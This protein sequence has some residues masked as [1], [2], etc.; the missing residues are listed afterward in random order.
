MESDLIIY[1]KHLR[2][3]KNIILGSPLRMRSYKLQLN[4]VGSDY[5]NL[6]YTRRCAP[7]LLTPLSPFLMRVMDEI[8]EMMMMTIDRN[9]GTLTLG[10]VSL[11]DLFQ[12]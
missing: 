3:E 4:K 10:G 2:E 1:K 12:P 9:K 5:I 8:Q 11:A 7:C 6:F